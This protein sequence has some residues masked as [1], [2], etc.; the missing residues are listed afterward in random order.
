M[1]MQNISTRPLNGN[2]L[3]MRI[4]RLMNEFNII[5]TWRGTKDWTKPTAD[6]KLRLNQL[7]QEAIDN[8][9]TRRFS[10]GLRYPELG[11]SFRSNLDPF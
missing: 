8:N 7:D 10:P 1:R 9:S 2:V 11:T 5:Y 3:S 4:S 6:Q